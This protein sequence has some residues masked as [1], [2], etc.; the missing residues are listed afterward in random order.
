MARNVILAIGKLL[1][2]IFE[3]KMV[4][5]TEN[6]STI[7]TTDKNGNGIVEVRQEII[8]SERYKKIGLILFSLLWSDFATLASFAI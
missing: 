7:T 1:D 8:P 4:Y 5:D 2:G 3:T 6:K